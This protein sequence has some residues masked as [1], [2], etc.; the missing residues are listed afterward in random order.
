MTT[1]H[2]GSRWSLW[3]EAPVLS[4]ASKRSVLSIGSIGSFLSV[5]SI[6]SAASLFSAGSAGQCGVALLGRLDVVRQSWGSRCGG[7]P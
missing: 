4:I 7:T 6:G 1:A 2:R 5:G 3:S